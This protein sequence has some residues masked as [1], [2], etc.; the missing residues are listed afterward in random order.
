MK[1]I[2]FSFQTRVLGAPADWDADTHGP[3]EG[4]PVH[5]DEHA[6]EYF[7]VWRPTWRERLRLLFG[8]TVGLFVAGRGHPPVS[9]EV[10]GADGR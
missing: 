5:I 3:C 8:G 1:P 7:S 4:L 9:L 2:P 10:R 6:G